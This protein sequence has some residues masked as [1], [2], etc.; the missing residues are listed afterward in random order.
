MIFLFTVADGGL[1]FRRS[2]EL[3]FLGTAWIKPFAEFNGVSVKGSPLKC[4]E[5]SP[6]AAITLSMDSQERLLGQKKL[7]ETM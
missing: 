4:Q 6:I 7:S 5:P 3:Q 1:M 2:G